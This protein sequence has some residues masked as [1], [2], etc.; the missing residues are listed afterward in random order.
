ML[1]IKSYFADRSELSKDRSRQFFL[2]SCFLQSANITDFNLHSLMSMF[3]TGK[4][5]IV[6]FFSDTNAFLENRFMQ[7]IRYS[8]SFAIEYRFNTFPD[9]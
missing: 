3:L 5:T 8:G 4:L 7:K 2:E 6:G 9:G 1:A